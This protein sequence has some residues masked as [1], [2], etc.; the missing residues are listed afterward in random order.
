MMCVAILILDDQ[1]VSGMLLKIVIEGVKYEKF[2][3]NDTEGKG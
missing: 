2:K 3:I 1:F